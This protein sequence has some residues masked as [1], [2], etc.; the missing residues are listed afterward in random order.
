MLGTALGAGADERAFPRALGRRDLL[1]P[2]VATAVARVLVVAVRERDRGRADVVWDQAVFRT[3]RVAQHAV[4]AQGVL[5]ELPEFSRRLQI[6]AVGYRLRLL[7]DEVRPDAL[8]LF[9]EV[10][11]D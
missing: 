6:L 10:V 1:L 7:R 4:D 3:G 2:L 5:L 9:H 8:Q 11:D